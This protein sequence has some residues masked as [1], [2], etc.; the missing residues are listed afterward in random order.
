ML[1]LV[2]VTVKVEILVTTGVVVTKM[3]IVFVLAVVVDVLHGFD[4]TVSKS[5]VSY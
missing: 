2:L 3:E 4:V 5:A 1:E